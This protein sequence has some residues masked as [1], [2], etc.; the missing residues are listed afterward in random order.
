VRARSLAAVRPRRGIGEPLG[1]AAL[2]VFSCLVAP[3]GLL[4]AHW[5]GDVIYYGTIGERIVNGEIPYHQIYLEYPPGAIP[6]FALPALISQHHYVF[7]FKVLMT[8]CAAVAAAAGMVV[9]RHQR[10]GGRARL[11]GAAL[12]GFAPLLVGPLFLNRYDV[13]PTMLV[14]LALL[15]LVVNRPRLCFGLLAVAIVAKIYPIAILPIAA[16][17]V[18]RTRGRRELNRCLGVLVAVGLVFVVPF[19]VVGFGGLGFS[20]YIQATRHLQIESLGAQILV[21][22]HHFGL[23]TATVILGRPGSVDLAGGVAGAVGVL[24]S[25]VE[26]ALVLLV[27]VWY[28]RGGVDTRRLVLASVTA[29]VAFA[30][31]GK[32]LSPQYLVWLALLVP[33]TSVLVSPVASLLLVVALVLTQIEFYD[34]D[35][36]SNLGPVSWLLLARNVVL[37][38]LFVV[39]AQPLRRSAQ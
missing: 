14:A 10:A 12:L 37:V 2:T 26:V 35:Q 9:L 13:W 32:V 17:H 39:L 18:G 29:I 36:V 19:A 3:G 22:F 30:T 31:F 1:V 16:I 38:A 23:Y 21:A 33:L 34:S 11:G 25:L 4:S 6:V 28:F 24:S 15:A 20:F 7:L 5:P 8:A 27:A